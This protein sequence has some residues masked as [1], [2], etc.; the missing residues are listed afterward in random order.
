MFNYKEKKL[1]PG[2]SFKI[3]NS[4]IDKVG[5]L[6]EKENYNFNKIQLNHKNSK[7]YAN[8]IV[9]FLKEVAYIINSCQLKE[10]EFVELFSKYVN[11]TKLANEGIWS[12]FTGKDKSNAIKKT[13][14]ALINNN[15]KDWIKEYFVQE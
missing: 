6:N 13:R 9:S 7:S 3:S 2:S 1:L 11:K 15:F 10:T 12:Q 8:I 4:F 14:T 5:Q